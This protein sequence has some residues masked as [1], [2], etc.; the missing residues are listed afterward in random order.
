[1][2]K[3]TNTTIRLRVYIGILLTAALFTLS[4]CGSKGNV[5]GKVYFKD[6]PLS[7]GGV[8]FVAKKKTVGTSQIGEDGSY[9]IKN[10]PAG[11]VTITVTM[12]V[13]LA[14][15]PGKTAPVSLP[16]EVSDPEKSTE[17]YTVKSGDQEYDIR[18]K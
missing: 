17:K 8:A 15:K 6:K 12:G 13:S 18:L 2:Q 16:K 10:V 1:M 4:G 9:D 14:A 3:Q 7:S 11:E 5:H